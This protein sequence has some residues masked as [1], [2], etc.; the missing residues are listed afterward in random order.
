MLSRRWIVMAHCCLRS[1]SRVTTN[2]IRRNDFNDKSSM[3][4]FD[5]QRFIMQ[6]VTETMPVIADVSN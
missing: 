6:I 3:I 4:A 5:P 1:I 2:I